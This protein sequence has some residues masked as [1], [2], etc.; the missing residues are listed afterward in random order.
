MLQ[1]SKLTVVPRRP[2]HQ[3]FLFQSYEVG[4]QPNAYN[5]QY[6]QST[7]KVTV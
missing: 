4:F 2:D 6:L 3:S 5:I 1:H 7:Y